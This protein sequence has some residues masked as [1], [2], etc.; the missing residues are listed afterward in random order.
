MTIPASSI[1]VRPVARAIRKNSQAASAEAMARGA[2][3]YNTMATA[4]G[5]A[6]TPNATRRASSE[7]K[8]CSHF[9]DLGFFRLDQLVHF[10]D[11]VVVQLLEVLL[12][13][14][15]VVLRNAGELL[16][17]FARVRTRV[18]DRDL[19]LFRVLVNDFHQLLAALLV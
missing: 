10:V 4:I 5:A 7:L 14:L 15:D 9:H 17:R 11:V 3:P 19:P 18:A 13:V 12:G 2:P 6:T 1:G 8:R 16:E